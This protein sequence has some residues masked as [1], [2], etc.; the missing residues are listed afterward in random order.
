MQ[1][2]EFVGGARQR[3]GRCA[4][5]RGTS[6]E[7]RHTVVLPSASDQDRAVSGRSPE[8]CA[9]PAPLQRKVQ[10]QVNAPYLSMAYTME[11]RRHPTK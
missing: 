4:S 3:L 10:K 1:L 5:E 11:D 2:R 7:G 9:N 8:G 6:S